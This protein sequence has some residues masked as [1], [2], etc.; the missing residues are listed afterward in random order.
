MKT[1]KIKTSEIDNHMS[2]FAAARTKSI[3]KFNDSYSLIIES[4]KTKF[5]IT[6]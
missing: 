3:M 5:E 6:N 1:V 4:K 2:G